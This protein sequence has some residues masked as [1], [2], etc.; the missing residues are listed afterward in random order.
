MEHTENA[1]VEVG[2]EKQMKE[3]R[4]LMQKET[5]EQVN[6]GSKATNT[7]YIDYTSEYGT[8]YKGNIVF[9]RPGLMDTMKM[10]AHKSEI[11]RL[12]GVKDLSMVDSGVKFMAQII[13]TLKTVIVKSPEWLVRIETVEDT[14]LIFHVYDEYNKWEL[15][16]RKATTKDTAV[17]ASQSTE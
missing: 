17:G 8:E 15:S 12:A 11:L 1:N 4:E 2:N 13:A 10:G 16:F 3:V 5:A 9:K 7:V 14:D 6:L